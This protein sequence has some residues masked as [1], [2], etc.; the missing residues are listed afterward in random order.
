MD[1]HSRTDQLEEYWKTH[2]LRATKDESETSVASTPSS[3]DESRQQQTRRRRA[4]SDATGHVL[5][6][7]V[8]SPDHPALS[9]AGLL[10]TFGPLAF[11]MY[12]AAL[13]RKKILIL[14]SAPVGRTCNYGA[15]YAASFGVCPMDVMLIIDSV[16]PLHILQHPALS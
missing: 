11:P 6:D 10:D 1:D 7:R 13:L 14:G 12:R 4:A 8:L 2:S 16:R 3:P 15:F 9:M 5:R